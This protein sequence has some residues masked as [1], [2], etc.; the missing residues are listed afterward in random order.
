M[1]TVTAKERKRNKTVPAAPIR[2]GPVAR[3]DRS[4]RALYLAAGALAAAVFLVFANALANGFVFDD[5]NHVLNKP[6][7]RS[8]AKLPEV[9]VSSYRPVRDISHMLEFALWGEWAAGFHLTNIL[10]HAVNTLL[11]FFLTRRLTGY[12]MAGMLAALIFAVHPI[13]TDAVTYVSGRRDLLFT[14]FYLSGFF[15]YLRY[16]KSRS[17][18]HLALFL[19]LWAL[20][21]MSKE[22]AATLPGFIFVWNFCQQWGEQSG[23]WASRSLKAA[24]AAFLLDRWLYL[25]LF[26]AVPVYAYYMVYV[27]GGSTRAGDYGLD[28]W[29]GSFYTNLLTVF[30]VHAW[31]LKQLVF[32]TPVVQ[33]FGAF[34]VATSLADP[35]VIPSIL[36]VLAVFAAGLFLLNKD[37]LMAFAILSYFVLLLPVSHI[38]PHHE[39]LA[40]HYLY[41]PMM[42]F[43]LLAALAAQK[44][45]AQGV[46][47]RRAVY[48][49]AAAALIALSVMTVLRNR[50]WKD[51]LTLWQANY[52]EAP[53]SLRAVSSLAALYANR[54]PKRAEELFKRCIE[55][56]P[57]YAPAY[58]SLAILMQSKEKAREVEAIIERG[59][60]LPDEKTVSVR[61]RD[62]RD[63]RSQLLTALA[64]AKGNQGDRAKT[65]ELLLQAIDLYP[66]NPQPYALLA[67]YY[68]DVDRDKEL[69]ILNR[70]LAAQPHRLDALQR[71]AFL[72]IEDKKYDEALPLLQRMLALSPNDYF[73][74]YNLGQYYRVNTDCGKARAHLNA[75][76]AATTK[77]DEIKL[78]Q[79]AL[80]QLDQVCR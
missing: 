62:P 34:D 63:F 21:L 46:T 78:V 36:L 28:Y 41:L 39:L 52:E 77:E 33:Y 23:S 65:E 35:R 68:H 15:C 54:N 29:G 37:R 25:A 58:V 49:A 20:G 57:A 80:R 72:K 3:P 38:I 27:K 75:A 13:Q 30:V 16:R 71:I 73:A 12:L 19:G 32:P 44:F 40:D 48:A 6:Q 45:A 56:D 26:A 47:A 31:Y 43:G 60:A 66:A 1:K 67:T 24:R 18:L 22:M 17:L 55:L 10:L 14:S 9:L 42:S 11:V 59:L 76:R 79:N 50:V 64:L 61:D 70:Q 74:N 53:N 69:D 2:R 51:D 7:F 4:P 8:L 5:H